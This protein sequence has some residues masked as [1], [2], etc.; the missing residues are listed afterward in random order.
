M[1]TEFLL[2]HLQGV[3]FFAGAQLFVS[4]LNVIG[5]A[6]LN[7]KTRSISG[8]RRLSDVKHVLPRVSI[9][10]PARNE[11]HNIEAC[12]RSLLEQEYSDY[13]LIILDDHSR[14]GTSEILQRIQVEFPR[15][16]ILKGQP[17]PEGWVGKTWACHQL[18]EKA[19]GEYL[20]FTDA[21]TRHH[22]EMLA[23]AIAYVT[24]RRMDFISGMPRQE[25]RTWGERLTVPFLSWVIFTLVP[26][27][28]ARRVRFPMLSAAVGQFIL[29]HR[30]AYL[31]IGG[32][33]QVRKSSVEDLLL[34]REVKGRGLRWDFLD[35]SERVA[36]RMYP[37]FASAFNGISKNLFSVFQYNLPIFAFV[38]V[39]LLL[40][41]IEPPLLM[42]ARAAG[43]PVPGPVLSLALA[44]YGLS[45]LLWGINNWKFRLPIIQAGFYPVTVSLLFIMAVRSAW[46]TYT[47]R[48]FDWKGRD[49]PLSK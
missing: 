33:K 25:L 45:L 16:K 38:W 26:I 44:I 17:L 14:D 19:N 3:L 42:L 40:V 43:I 49:L 1:Y 35:L 7:S 20:L 32:H 47:R 30:D 37:D 18:A 41:N 24:S 5:V 27:P 9:L 2:Q 13:E 23:D 6:R 46:Y 12:A 4:L 21:D 11:A 29:F 31:R 48:P 8:S 34:V 15:L 22:A 10:V 39:W 28:I 36:C